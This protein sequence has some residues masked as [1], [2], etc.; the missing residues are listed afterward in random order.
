[1]VSSAL[2]SFS[3][4]GKY[5]MDIEKALNIVKELKGTYDSDTPQFYEAL[6]EVLRCA[7]R[8]WW[9]RKNN[10]NPVDIKI[11]W[12]VHFVTEHG[13][14]TIRPVEEIELDAEI[15]LVMGYKN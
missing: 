7:E 11:P 10:A 5:K 12:C 2:V 3:E 6:D 13:L 8:Y 15:D 9:L 4:H 1:M 14:P